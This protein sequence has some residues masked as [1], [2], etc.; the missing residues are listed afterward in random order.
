MVRVIT[1]ITTI[2]ILLLL[3]QE[4]ISQASV[5]E[6]S[7]ESCIQLCS[8]DSDWTQCS[9]VDFVLTE[10]FRLG[11]SGMLDKEKIIKISRM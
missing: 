3:F 1:I 11:E 4:L 10:Q 7:G 8:A 9:V 6:S 5:P 2:I